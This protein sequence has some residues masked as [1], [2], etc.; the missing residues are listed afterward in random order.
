MTQGELFS[1]FGF[2][3]MTKLKKK[4]KNKFLLTEC[5]IL[6]PDQWEFLSVG[7]LT[8]PLPQLIKIIHFQ[9]NTYLVFGSV[10]ENAGF[11]Q[12][13]SCSFPRKS[14]EEESGEVLWGLFLIEPTNNSSLL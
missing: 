3:L 13:S 7:K 11:Q 5:V 12:K 4:K 14:Y 10:L 6:P 9:L 2:F 1:R 8:S